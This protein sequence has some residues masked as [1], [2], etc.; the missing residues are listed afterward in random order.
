LKATK[1]RLEAV[2]EELVVAFGAEAD[3][4]RSEEQAL[5]A[6]ADA[7]DS[8]QQAL[9]ILANSTSYGIFVE[10]NVAALEAPE[11]LVCYGPNGDGFSVE[12]QKVEEPGRY[13]HPLLATLVTGAARLMLGLAERVCIE[14]GLDWAFCD[15]D[16]LAIA[17]PD[18]MDQ[19][20]F[21]ERAQ[22]ICDWF[23]PLNPY[24]QKGPIFKIEDANYSIQCDSKIEPLY[25]YCI[26]A[27][28]YVLFNR[29]PIGEIIIRKASAHGLGQYLP[30]YE[31]DDA[32]SSI[33]A[34]LVPLGDIGVERWQ[35]DLWYMVI[36]AALEGHP[37]QV[38]LSYHENLKRPAV[39]RYGATTPALLKWF[40]TFN[41]GREYPEQ[42]KPFNFL[43]A[44]HARPQFELPDAEQ[45]AKANR[46]RPKKQ[47][48]VKPVSAFN[49]NIREA[50]KAAFDRESGKPV[51]ASLLM[52]YTEALAQY[53]LRPESKFLNGDFCDRGRTERRHVV[54]TQLLHIGKEANKWEEQY[55]LGEDEDA[56]IEYGV[57]QSNTSLDAAIRES[58]ETAG[59]RVS[60]EKLGISRTALRRA[61]KRGVGSLSR[62]TRERILRRMHFPG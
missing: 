35:Y 59:E 39:S 42:V 32:P 4:L 6:Q 17:K 55:F 3:A 45:W 14:K 19:A 11:R 48:E 54:A 10:F 57:D 47:S 36:S 5:T 56:E 18:G 16:S 46:G 40:T 26:S 30:P 25:C 52:T 13:F 50:A 62:A 49:K 60:A 44:Y 61:L 1:R 7:F 22:S 43:N 41:R 38:D 24:E 9:K 37:D 33:P 51:V 28:R 53:H 8:D 23:L 20:E 12:S 29:G 34:P 2:R 21:L 15:T 31:A 27:K 58:C